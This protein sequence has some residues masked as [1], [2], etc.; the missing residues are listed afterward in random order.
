M[1]D[2]IARANKYAKSAGRTGEGQYRAARENETFALLLSSTN[3]IL[4]AVV[5][6]FNFCTVGSNVPPAFR[7]SRHCCRR[8]K[9][10]A[11]H[12]EA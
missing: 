6:N 11:T 8:I 10:S 3:T 9:R 2:L 7:S 1:D 5:G 12:I 4:S